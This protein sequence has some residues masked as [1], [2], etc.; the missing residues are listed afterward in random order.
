[1]ICWISGKAG[2]AIVLN[3]SRLVL[4][5]AGTDGEPQECAEGRL[6]Q[7]TTLSP[8]VQTHKIAIDGIPAFERAKSLLER[9][10]R[11]EWAL[12]ALA[13]AMDASLT[14]ALREEARGLASKLFEDDDILRTTRR[15][16]LSVPIPVEADTHWATTADPTA[17]LV[18]DA[19]SYR[20]QAGIA[21]TAWLQVAMRTA[22]PTDVLAEFRRTAVISGGFEAI[23]ESFAAGTRDPF[24]KW[25]ALKSD[26]RTNEKGLI[27]SWAQEV[28]LKRL[29]ATKIGT[30]A[31]R[32]HL[33]HH[34]QVG[35]K[36]IYPNHGLGIVERIED[37]T[38]LGTTCGFYH[39]RIVANDTTVLVPVSNVGGIGLRRAIRTEEVERLFGLLGDGKID[40]QQNWKGRLKDNSDK[41]RSGSIYEVA[42]VLKSL[43]FL[44][45]SKSLSFREKRMLDRAKFLIVSEVSEVMGK[46][47]AEIEVRIDVALED[48]FTKIPFQ[49]TKKQQSAAREATP[50]KSSANPR[51]IA[52][53]KRR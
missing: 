25:L 20:H 43:T 7:L 12:Q 36:V 37:R 49:N 39:L 51:L 50:L 24:S 38:I 6:H 27:E 26:W 32:S 2:E 19:A 45:K 47:P 52:P 17:R 9:S 35:D 31:P 13:T 23:R 40:S 1:M 18:A 46:T 10:W 29:L 44:A 22:L 16:F 3:E 28:F 34:F 14:A 41:M 42:D 5:Q 53:T 21:A 15:L 30:S 8:D 48:C 4:I 11:L 33:S